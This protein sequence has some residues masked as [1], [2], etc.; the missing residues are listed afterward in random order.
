MLRN[1]TNNYIFLGNVL[2]DLS[3][4]SA[5]Q[6]IMLSEEEGAEKPGPEIFAKTLQLVNRDKDLIQNPIHPKQCLHIGD[7][8]MW[9]V[10]LAC[11]HIGNTQ[12]SITSVIQ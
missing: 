12:L 1:M 2:K 4:P 10:M 8:L 11:V 7:E 9:S 6:P 5:L 3:F